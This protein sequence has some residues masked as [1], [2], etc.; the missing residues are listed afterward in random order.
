MKLSGLNHF[1]DDEPHYTSAL[2]FT[3]SVI[4]VFG[5]DRLVWGSGSPEIVDV[6]LSAAGF[7]EAEDIAKV[8]GGNLARLIDW[9]TSSSDKPKL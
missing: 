1:A 8:R 2:A 5:P 3:T 6:H 9:G 7:G 4:K